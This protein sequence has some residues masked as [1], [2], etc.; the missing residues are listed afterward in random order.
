MS[1]SIS[2]LKTPLLGLVLSAAILGGSTIVHQTAGD[3]DKALSVL[4]TT[5]T[6][7]S[8][9]DDTC[10]GWRSTGFGPCAGPNG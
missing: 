6:E 7:A 1:I 4:R 3:S 2:H 8:S 9:V 5:T 10:N